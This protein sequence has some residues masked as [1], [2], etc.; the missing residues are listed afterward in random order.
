MEN[1][2]AG[3]ALALAA[4]RGFLSL[5]ELAARLALCFLLPPFFTLLLFVIVNSSSSLSPSSARSSSSSES[6]SV[7]TRVAGTP[8]APGSFLG[9]LIYNHINI[10]K[11][12]ATTVKKKTQ[13][14]EPLRKEFT[15]CQSMIFMRQ[16][17][18]LV[19]RYLVC[20]WAGNPHPLHSQHR[21]PS[22]HSEFASAAQQP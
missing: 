5:P 18:P 10:P 16:N 14:E 8:A 13:T 7:E 6:A 2:L 17:M 4:L 21:C 12:T 1:V 22:R 19:G 20:E 9:V 3:S 11:A 15:A